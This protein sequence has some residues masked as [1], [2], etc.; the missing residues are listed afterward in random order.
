LEA[1]KPD[2]D[3][4]DALIVSLLALTTL[5]INNG[6]AIGDYLPRRN[7]KR[8]DLS[9]FDECLSLISES[10]VREVL[11]K[12]FRKSPEWESFPNEVEK[13]VTVRGTRAIDGAVIPRYI[14][15]PNRF[16]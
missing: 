10:R 3:G 11:R 4:G 6:K 12:F 9:T 15:V 1:E 2:F 14:V 5:L 7:L 8:E 13:L 16:V